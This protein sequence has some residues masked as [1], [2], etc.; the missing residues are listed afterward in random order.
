[1]GKTKPQPGRGVLQKRSQFSCWAVCAKRSQL[2]IGAVRQNEATLGAHLCVCKTN[3]TSCVFAKRTQLLGAG[4]A[5]TSRI[6][7]FC[8]TNPYSHCGLVSST[9]RSQLFG[10]AVLCKTKPMWE[11]TCVFGKTNP[12]FLGMVCSRYSPS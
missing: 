2:P 8:E 3:P 6:E 11:P 12:T 1:V 9:K 4:L 10:H 7:V 5:A